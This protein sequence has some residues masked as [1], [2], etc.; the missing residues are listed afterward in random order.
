MVTSETA[1]IATADDKASLGWAAT[2]RE[3]VGRAFGDCVRA[4][5]LRAAVLKV[6][7]VGVVLAAT[8]ALVPAPAQAYSYGFS[9]SFGRVGGPH[10]WIVM[11]DAELAQA[12]FRAAAQAACARA[13]GIRFSG[14]ACGP[15]ID[16][17]YR[18]IDWRRWTNHGVFIE[19]RWDAKRTYLG[20]W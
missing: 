18:A 1:L 13:L 3:G 8:V 19:I 2:M 17:M 5:R 14:Q 11:T 9:S 20:R 4:V 12:S 16:A 6:A 7:A 10:A 15:A